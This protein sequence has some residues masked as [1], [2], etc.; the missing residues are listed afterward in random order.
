MSIKNRH[1]EKSRAWQGRSGK[2]STDFLCLAIN[3]RRIE[4]RVPKCTP[5]RMRLCKTSRVSVRYPYLSLRRSPYEQLRVILQTTTRDTPT[6]D[7]I[8]SVTKAVLDGASIAAAVF[9][10][11]IVSCRLTR[12]VRPISAFAFK[13]RV[14]STITWTSQVSHRTRLLLSSLSLFFYCTLRQTTRF[15]NCGLMKKYYHPRGT[16]LDGFSCA[17]SARIPPSSLSTVNASERNL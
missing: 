5:T 10:D 8:N 1:A 15:Y 16:S 2:N 13:R 3:E 11:R 7:L 14:A 6:D 17:I 12:L 9:N 4:I